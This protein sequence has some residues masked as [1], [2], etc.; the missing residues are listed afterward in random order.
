MPP[1]SKFLGVDAEVSLLHKC[2]H[3]RDRAAGK[4]VV[5]KASSRVS[6]FV[7]K[8]L[9]TRTTRKVPYMCAVQKCSCTAVQLQKKK[10]V[11]GRNM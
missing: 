2:L 3:P 10:D 7:V 1:I 4:F 11:T 9:E 8:S 5:E 6:G